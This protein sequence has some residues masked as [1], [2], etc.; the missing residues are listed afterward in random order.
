M[1]DSLVLCLLFG[2]SYLSLALAF[3][4]RYD[5]PAE[6]F[7]PLSRFWEWVG[8]RTLA[9]FSVVVF[10]QTLVACIWKAVWHV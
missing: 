3:L 6:K 2:V 5:V 8:D 7:V 1:D 10:A 4:V 9:T